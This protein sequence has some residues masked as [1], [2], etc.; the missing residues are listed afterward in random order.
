MSND[1]QAPGRARP[2]ARGIGSKISNYVRDTVERLGVRGILVSLVSLVL[3]YSFLPGAL[4]TAWAAWQGGTFSQAEAVPTLSQAEV[5]QIKVL[6]ADL[7]EGTQGT[8][9]VLY[10][11][12]EALDHE[13]VGANYELEVLDE[14]DAVL[15]T[16]DGYALISGTRPV[17]EV[18]YIEAVGDADP[19]KDGVSFATTATVDLRHVEDP[20]LKVENI[21]L[22]EDTL[23]YKALV[24]VSSELDARGG[25]VGVVVRD[26]DGEIIAIQSH[27]TGGIDA[28][29]VEELDFMMWGLTELPVDYTIETEVL[30]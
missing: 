17:M 9:F 14:N 7:W 26:A 10:L 15:G 24:T 16:A 12:G 11:S 30:P 1:T 20:K 5:D 22:V 13:F 27:F 4:R 23:S 25:Q 3:A 21:E 29:G 8:H 18:G 6:G 19:A 2:G 28:G